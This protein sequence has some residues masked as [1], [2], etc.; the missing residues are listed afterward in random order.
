MKKYFLIIIAALIPSLLPAME[1]GV[2]KFGRFKG[3]IFMPEKFDPATATLLLF[4]PGRGCSEDEPGN[5]GTD[6]FKKFRQLCSDNNIVIATPGCGADSWGNDRALAIGQQMVRYLKKTLKIKKANYF[7][8]GC[9]M[10]G[11]AA[12]CYA[13]KYNT[14]VLAVCDVFGVTDLLGQ[15]QNHP[16]YKGSMLKAYKEPAD[17]NPELYRQHSAIN[18]V[19]KLKNIPLLIMHGDQ[20]NEVN[21]LQSLNLQSALEKAGSQKS[22]FIK[23]PGAGH[24]NEII[25]GYEQRVFD[26][27]LEHK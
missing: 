8:M 27:F 9:S 11:G 18:Q 24:I 7:V 12:L 1:S 6:V 23:V 14:E 5:I 19:E 25:I 21:I 15:L 13:A 26:F 2:I 3:Y 10:G 16:K 22:E 4:Y 17:K 20:D